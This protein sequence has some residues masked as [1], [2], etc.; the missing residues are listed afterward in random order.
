MNTL[1]ILKKISMLAAGVCITSVS[2]ASTAHA[3]II[4]NPADPNNGNCFPFSCKYSGL[5]TRYQQVYNSDLFSDAVVID[6]ISFFSTQNSQ[7]SNIID[8]ANYEISLSTTPKAVNALDTVNFS[9][10][11][12]TDNSLFFQGKLGGSIIGK[13]FSISAKSSFLYNPAK[14]NLLLDIFKTNNLGDGSGLL[15]A[16]SGTFGNDS[17]R[18]HNF[19][20]GF[21]SYG[22]VTEF[23]TYTISVPEPASIT[24]LLAFSAL[25]AGSALKRKQQKA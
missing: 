10:N 14:G 2:L 24:G 3:I 25:G 19:G 4:G 12:G 8:T 15:D 17:S 21:K 18:A 16:R 1:T 13:T 5:G 22:L 7:E 20:T 9:S 23:R 11:V 6:E